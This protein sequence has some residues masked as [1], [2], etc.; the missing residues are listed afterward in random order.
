MKIVHYTRREE[1]EGVVHYTRREEDD[2]EGS[3][4][5]QKG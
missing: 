3:T 5:N 1:D 2:Y 4:L